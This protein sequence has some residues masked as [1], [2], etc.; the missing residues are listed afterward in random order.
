MRLGNHRHRLELEGVESLARQQ[1]GFDEMA[2][3]AAA[4]AFG[5]LVFGKRGE[6]PGRGPAFLVRPFGKGGN[7]A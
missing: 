2:L 4:V 1:S 7:L 3:D 6:E 5:N